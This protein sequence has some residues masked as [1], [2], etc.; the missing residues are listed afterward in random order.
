MPSQKAGLRERLYVGGHVFTRRA[1]QVAPSWSEMFSVEG[2][3][4]GSEQ[5]GRPAPFTGCADALLKLTVAI[6]F[7]RLYEADRAAV[8]LLAARPGATDYCDWKAIYERFTGDGTRDFVLS[9]RPALT[10][11]DSGFW[12]TLAA[13]K[14]AT[15]V[16]IDGVAVTPTWGTTNAKFRKPFNVPS[17]TGTAE[18]PAEI[19]VCFVPL[20]RM[21]R[22]A[23]V[24]VYSEP[25]REDASFTLVQTN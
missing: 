4:D 2:L 17:Y 20:F 25:H 10:D 24:P 13:T 23:P 3:R 5:T 19:L 1:A 11:L 9:S 15:V 21:R 22:V 14:Y 18:T 6:T 8:A 7:A 16:T 12:P